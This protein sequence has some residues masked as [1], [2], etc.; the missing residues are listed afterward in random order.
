MDEEVGRDKGVRPGWGTHKANTQ[1]RLCGVCVL[2]L[3]WL[4]LT[5]AVLHAAEQR[6]AES[7][8]SIRL[9]PSLCPSA[10][11][12]SPRWQK[13][14]GWRDGRGLAGPHT[15]LLACLPTPH[16][17][18]Q[19]SRRRAA[20]CQRECLRPLHRLRAAYSA[21]PQESGPPLCFSDSNRAWPE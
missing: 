1:R 12:I 4:W 15:R 6:E 9:T 8:N 2:S 20:E 14:K 17:P 5:V 11:P 16:L 7:G 13:R 19:L 18:W 21:P 3:G 10:R